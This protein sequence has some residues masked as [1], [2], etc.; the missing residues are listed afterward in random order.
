MQ[1]WALTKSDEQREVSTGLLERAA[2]NTKYMFHV[3]QERDRHPR[4]LEGVMDSGAAE[5][6]A[7]ANISAE[8]AEMDPRTATQ[9][10]ITAD[11]NAIFNQGANIVVGETECGQRL[12]MKYQIAAVSKPLIYVSKV[13]GRGNT[14]IFSRE[15]GSIVPDNGG[16]EIKFK[17]KAG[18]YVLPTWVQEHTSTTSFLKPGGDP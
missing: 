13:C 6:V 14:V 10:Y 1:I 8:P 11:G 4:L 5:S 16:K 12:A 17:R 2:P 9:C 3:D 18:V 7:P 15:G